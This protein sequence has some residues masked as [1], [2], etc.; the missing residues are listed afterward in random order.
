M[1]KFIFIFCLFLCLA[2]CRHSSKNSI[3]LK[4]DT[5]GDFLITGEQVGQIRKGMSINDVYDIFPENQIKKIRSKTELTAKAT[6]NFYIYDNQNRLLLIISPTHANNVYS[7]INRIV[8]KDNRYTTEKGI[9]LHSTVGEIETAY[10]NCN[11]LPSVNELILYVPEVNANFQINSPDL[12]QNV[13]NDSTGVN[14]ANIPPDTP[15]NTLVI[16]WTPGKASIITLTFWHDLLHHFFNWAL[17]Q[18]PSIILLIMIFIGTLRLLGFSV[19]RLKKMAL[20]RA[21]KYNQTHEGE[22]EKRI[23]TLA[24]IILGI[25]KIFLWV[26]FLL[27]L[28]GKFNINIGPLLASAGIVGLA[29]GFGAQELVRDFISGFFMLLEDEIRTGDVAIINGTAGTVEKIEM[30]TTTLRDASGIVHIFQN[31]KINTLSNMTKEWSA[32]VVDIRIAYKEDTDRVSRI[33]E[34][35]GNE[36]QQDPVYGEKM[37]RELEVWGID[38]FADS[39]VIIKVKLTTKAGQQW[40][41]GR[42]LRRRVKKAFDMANIEIPFPHLSLY[43]GSVTKPIPIDLKQ[44]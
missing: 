30:R 13:W 21:E 25:G 22:T 3:D 40:A 2:A 26:V 19:K 43:S 44:K 42:E 23:N 8:V 24:G 6:D 41:T 27:I 1:Q 14:A 31:G 7:A 34:Q 10:P 9:T 11:F 39:A 18:L 4:A 38:Q 5:S 36:M 28:L 35:I 37:L 12:P 16:F 32:I 20:H 15:V 29:I 17:N 33:L